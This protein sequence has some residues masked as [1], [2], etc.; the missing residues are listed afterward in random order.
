MVF[1]RKYATA[2]TI[3]GVPLVTVGSSDYK[4]SPTLAAG[5]AQISKDGGA[6]ANLATLPA[7]TPAAGRAVRVALSATEATAARCVIQ[8]V[9]QT[10]PKEWEDQFVI[11]E[12]FGHASAQEQID[13]ADVVRAGLTALPNAA[14]EAAGGLYTR[15][16]GAGQINQEANGQIDANAVKVSGDPTAADN[17][18]AMYEGALLTGS[19]TNAA[20]T[21]TTFIDTT[22][23]ATDSFY[24]GAVV[25]FSSGTLKGLARRC[26][27]Y[28][29]ST[30]TFTTDAWPSAPAQN[31][32]FVILGR[33]D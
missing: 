20:P 8:F 27:S 4:A 31:D 9:D 2:A 33:I 26:N 23:S 10:A 14:A 25:A 17:L 5:D 7:V 3:D 22:K 16:T 15:G 6:F 11:V 32:T 24:V 28:V 12:T 21:T 19:V 18:E 30:K 13:Y 1:R 29:G